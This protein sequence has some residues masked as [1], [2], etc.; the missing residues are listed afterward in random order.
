MKRTKDNTI[1]IFIEEP[2]SKIARKC[3]DEMRLDPKL[4]SITEIICDRSIIRQHYD[5][6]ERKRIVADIENKLLELQNY[7]IYKHKLDTLMYFGGKS[8]VNFYKKY[9]NDKVI[10]DLLE[11]TNIDKWDV[12]C[13][14]SIVTVRK[15]QGA[16]NTFVSEEVKH[17]SNTLKISFSCDLFMDF[18]VII[19][20]NDSDHKVKLCMYGLMCNE[21]DITKISGTTEC[22]ELETLAKEVNITSEQLF[23]LFSYVYK[24]FMFDPMNILYTF[25]LSAYNRIIGKIKR[26]ISNDKSGFGFSEPD[27]DLI[28]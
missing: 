4:A 21:I 28:Y 20:D 8:K 19:S 1:A 15:N 23:E 17:Y 25:D 18:D 12:K 14:T 7:D 22:K 10:H 13:Y 5:G 24:T 9:P 27:I 3:I 6:E 26:G 2:K 11:N 16:I